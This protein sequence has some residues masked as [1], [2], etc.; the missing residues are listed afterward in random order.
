MLKT[1]FA[2]A[3]L[4]LV[5]A[6]GFAHADPITHGALEIDNIWARATP[7]KARAAGGFMTI[8]NTG[9]KDVQFVAAKADISK[10]VEIHEMAVVNDIMKMKALP[11]GLTIPAGKTVMLKPGS[12]HVM[13][14]GL[15]DGLKAGE[16]F[17]LTLQFSGEADLKVS[18][19]VKMFKGKMHMKNKTM[20]SMDHG[21]MD[22]G[23]MGHGTDM[24]KK[25]DQ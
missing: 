21:K 9:S 22:H 8:K 25:M 18:M 3:S 5:L 19:P 15:K 16:A 12:Y 6:S 4:G 23:K 17:D 10:K 20:K 2:T 13:F 14:I 11:K 7:P 24:K 1:V